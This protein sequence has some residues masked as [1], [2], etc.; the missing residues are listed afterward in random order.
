MFQH[1]ALSSLIVIKSCNFLIDSRPIFLCCNKRTM[2]PAI[3]Y[4]SGMPGS[5]DMA[6]QLGVSAARVVGDEGKLGIDRPGG[7][8]GD[9]TQGM[10]HQECLQTRGTRTSVTENTSSA[11]VFNASR[12]KQTHQRYNQT[13][14]FI[15]VI[16]FHPFDGELYGYRPPPSACL[17]EDN[18]HFWPPP[19]K[20]ASFIL[21]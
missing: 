21:Q 20:Q 8:Q 13:Y 19:I 2:T 7:G 1:F 11:W 16:H 9:P 18:Q 15:L 14:R 10:S 12:L 6:V 3:S 5:K 4:R 17:I